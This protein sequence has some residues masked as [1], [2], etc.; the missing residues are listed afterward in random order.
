MQSIL[1]YLIILVE[2]NYNTISDEQQRTMEI[3]TKYKIILWKDNFKNCVPVS[4]VMDTSNSS[5]ASSEENSGVES[6]KE[7]YKH[8]SMIIFN[9]LV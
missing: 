4:T 8:F 3:L 7:R 5:V 6:S 9:W 1:L 2:H